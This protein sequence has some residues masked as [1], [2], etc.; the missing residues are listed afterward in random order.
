VLGVNLKAEVW[1]ARLQVLR[2]IT[3]EWEYWYVFEMIQWKAKRVS[4]NL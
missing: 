4:L 3:W 1:A 2:H